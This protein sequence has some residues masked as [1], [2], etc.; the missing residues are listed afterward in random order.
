MSKLNVNFLIVWPS[1]I[2]KLSHRGKLI[3]LKIHLISSLAF[4]IYLCSQGFGPWLTVLSRSITLVLSGVFIYLITWH[5]V[6]KFCIAFHLV[7]TLVTLSSV[8]LGKNS[9]LEVI[10]KPY[11]NTTLMFL[12]NQKN[13]S[14]T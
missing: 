10:L 14:S 1:E 3:S 5:L 2:T 8:S 11:P 13:S 7:N 6:L 4:N 12:L 9:S